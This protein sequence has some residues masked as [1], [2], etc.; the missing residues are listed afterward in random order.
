MHED[1][2]GNVSHMELPTFPSGRGVPV[3]G[4]LVDSEARTLYSLVSQ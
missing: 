2:H 1:V 4:S 3:T